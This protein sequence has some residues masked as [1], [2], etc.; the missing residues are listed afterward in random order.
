ME[1]NQSLLELEIDQ[2]ASKSLIDAA[3]WARFIAIFIFVMMACIILVIIFMRSRINTSISKVFPEMPIEGFGFL[4][5]VV[6]GVAL[7][8]SV[9][10][11]FLLRGANLIKKGV[12]TNDQAVLTEGLRSLKIYFIIYGVL[13]II[14]LFFNLIALF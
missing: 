1:E 2:S 14:G 5:S 3:R 4:L 10:I 13:A 12:E 7:V 6:I 9:V 8:V 11:F